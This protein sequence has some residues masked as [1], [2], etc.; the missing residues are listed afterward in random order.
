MKLYECNKCGEYY[1]KK[2]EQCLYCDGKICIELIGT[3]EEVIL[4]ALKEFYFNEGN[5]EQFN[6][7]QIKEIIEE[8]LKK[9][10]KWDAFCKALDKAE[11]KGYLTKVIIYYVNP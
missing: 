5:Y 2:A 9:E 10:I 11:E 7:D 4:P 6:I 1:Y 3:S 8:K